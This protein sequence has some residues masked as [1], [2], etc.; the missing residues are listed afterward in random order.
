MIALKTRFATLLLIT[1]ATILCFHDVIAGNK[2][3]QRTLI[4]YFFQPNCEECAKVAELILPPLKENY[5]K[6]IVLK[7]YDL[8]EEN[9][10]LLLISILDSLKDESNH[11]V[12]MII[13]RKYILGGYPEIDRQLFRQLNIVCRTADRKK[14][15]NIVVSKE[16]AGTIGRRIKIGTVIVAGLIDGINPCVFSTLIFFMSLLAVAKIS[17]SRLLAV[18]AVYCLA[19]FI[20][21][22]LLGFGLFK[23]IQ[24]LSL[25]SLF[26]P[27]LNWSM[28]AVLILLA[29]LSFRDA[30]SFF[31][32]DGD[33]GKVI[34]QLPHKMKMIIHRLMRR[35][36]KSHYLFS[37]AFVIGVAV[38]LLESV[39]TGQVYIPT[40]VMLSNEAGV[41][42]KWFSL[43]LLYNLLFII[44]LIGVFILMYSGISVMKAVKLTRTNLIIGKVLLG[45]FFTVLA[46]LMVVL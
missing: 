46:I 5:G 4:E 8:S 14:G 28:I 29:L 27:I 34:L 44:P 7:K 6:R 37:G 11:N 31:R 21:Y 16:T 20:T 35:R 17:G 40:L 22:L 30:Y 33:S 9:N 32:S 1:I 19:C 45:I 36:I 38:T 41:F 10:F 39:C 43:L 3:S 13:N 2:S 42:S 26:K 12:Y 18:G 25:F 15:K 23:I 24:T